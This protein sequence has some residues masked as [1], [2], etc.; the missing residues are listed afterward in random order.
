MNLAEQVRQAGV[1][2]AWGGGFPTHVTEQ[3]LK[4][5]STRPVTV[6]LQLDKNLECLSRTCQ[7]DIGHLAALSGNL[8]LWAKGLRIAFLPDMKCGLPVHAEVRA[9]ATA[10]AGPAEILPGAIV[11]GNGFGKLMGAT[12][13]RELGEI[14]TP[15]LLT[16]TLNVPR[17]ADALE[18]VG[19][20]WS[21]VAAS[22]AAR[23]APRAA[24]SLSASGS[25]SLR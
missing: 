8:D 22:T 23:L 19:F 15:I 7:H 18:E 20:W 9:A 1:V 16:S 14:E 21:M 24:P 13:V 12:Q 6:A 2:G 17:V 3:A 11:V 10:A 5:K 4:L 25:S